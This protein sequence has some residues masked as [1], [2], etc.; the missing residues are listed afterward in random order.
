[1]VPRPGTRVWT[2]SDRSGRGSAWGLAVDPVEA[3]TLAL[4]LDVL[5]SDA[6]VGDILRRGFE[7][8]NLSAG[9][10]W[11]ALEALALRLGVLANL[12]ET[13]V[14]P[15]LALGAGLD[16]GGFRIDLGG[17]F[18][19]GTS[20]VEGVEIP[21]ETRITLSLGFGAAAG[22]GAGQAD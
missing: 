1:M 16:L 21:E 7:V 12:A 10:E 3:L 20:V 13:D 17:H 8:Q 19:F 11:R 6:F 9:L 22:D 5:P 2:G 14:G 4:D 18:S 15:A